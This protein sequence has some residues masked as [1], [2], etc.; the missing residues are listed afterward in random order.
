VKKR[1]WRFASSDGKAGGSCA[2][3][4]D[5]LQRGRGCLAQLVSEDDIVIDQVDI[6]N[7]LHVF[8]AWCA[9]YAVSRAGGCGPIVASALARKQC[10]ID[11]DPVTIE[12]LKQSYESLEAMASKLITVDFTNHVN[13]AKAAAASAA[14]N[15]LNQDAFRAAVNASFDAAWDSSLT[16]SNVLDGG[17]I[18]PRGG[19]NPTTW[20]SFNSRLEDIVDV[21]LEA[22]GK[23]N[24]A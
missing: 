2:R 1:L 14:W 20:N 3:I 6:E 4:I 13:R 12:Q 8:A 5:A 19:F 15:A 16:Y 21:A 24:A 22:Q 11:G 9:S 10:W 23:E 7:E 18:D 17:K